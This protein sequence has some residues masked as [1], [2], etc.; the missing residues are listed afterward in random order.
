MLKPEQI[1]GELREL[2]LGIP[3]YDSIAT[4][5]NCRFDEHAATV[6]MEF[7]PRCLRHV[8]GVMAGKPF[9]L[10][11]WQQSI[12]ANLFG[13]KR[14]HRKHGW[15][16]RYREVM[17]YVPRKN[18]KSPMAAGI[19]LFMFFVDKT[20][21]KQCYLAAG[22]REQASIVFRHA[23]GMVMQEPLL[24]KRCRIYGGTG[25]VYQSRSIVR[26]EEGSFLRVVSADADTKHGGNT[27]FAVIDELHVQPK[28]D[29][30]DVFAT[31][32]ASENIPQPLLIY[33]TT[34]DYFRE[35]ICNEKHD[36]AKKVRD[37]VIA[38]QAFLPIVYEID[39]ADD[40]TD[41]TVWAK[42]NPNL[43]VSVSLDY[44]QRE[45][46]KAREI[47]AYENTFRR[48]HLNQVTEQDVRWMPM[49][50]WNECNGTIDPDE[51][52]G[53]ECFAG[54]DISSTRD[55]TSLVLVFPDDDGGFTVLPFFWAPR[56]SATKR[57]KQD[58]QSYMGWAKTHIELTDGNSIDQ[59][60]IRAKMWELSEK[61]N[62]RS[63]GFDGWNMDECYQQLL[64]EGWPEWSLE[65]FPQTYAGYNEPM[66]KCLELVRERKLRHGGN[67]VLRWNAANVVAKEDPSGN[68]RPDKG[69]S[70][71]KI[72]GFCALLMGLGLAAADWKS[73][74]ATREPIFI[75][76]TDG[77]SRQEYVEE[78]DPEDYWGI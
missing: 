60:V 63:V 67:P 68:I 29:L 17:I 4:A 37:G 27:H 40:W 74:Y 58:K 52:I 19:G 18:G 33:V 61:Y 77:E 28:R 50:Y 41:E 16:R 56:D 25:S 54:L 11:K 35:S 8:E 42:C 36:Y 31:S 48:L 23:K 78:G 38:D 72:D 13:W 76:D 39:P 5:G 55:L 70:A 66:K 44:L 46:Q 2:L 1:E 69:K 53:R 10:E 73:A 71:D 21:G 59:S 51:L 7:F 47:P 3:G 22:D 45:C 49:E 24:E 9:A 30:V 62:I 6:A 26:E 75:G 20:A 57:D 34:A 12:I 64:R 32:M 14:Q 43:G 15:I 65:K